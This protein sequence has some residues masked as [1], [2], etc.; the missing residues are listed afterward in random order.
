MTRAFNFVEHASR[1]AESVFD[2][3]AS[4]MTFVVSRTDFL[5]RCAYAAR[6]KDSRSVRA[7]RKGEGQSV[8]RIL[9]GCNARTLLKGPEALLAAYA[10]LALHFSSVRA[11]Q[12]R[13]RC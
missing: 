11:S 10:H 6:I 8:V 3:V 13:V 12:M 5:P 1:E 4:H 9:L 2:T 7:P